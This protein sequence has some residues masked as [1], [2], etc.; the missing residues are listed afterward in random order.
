MN[1]DRGRRAIGWIVPVVVVGVWQVVVGS[2]LL[3]LESVPAPDGVA[4]ALL[5][6]IKSGDLVEDLLYTG[7]ITVLATLLAVTVGGALGLAI[8]LLPPLRLAVMASVDVLRTVP[9]VALMPIALLALGPLPGTEVLLAVWAAQW[10]VLI[11]VAGAVRAVPDRLYDVGRMARLSRAAMLRTIV[12]PAVVPA[13]L[14]GARLATIIALHVAIT[15][16]MVM[17]PNGLGGAMVRSMQSLDVER[18]FAYAVVCGI[19][20]ALVSAGLRRLVAAGLPGSTA[21]PRRGAW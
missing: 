5:D 17:A 10:P 7:G 3:H 11:N 14:V 4:R 8:G 2:G 19:V 18:V 9:A 13:G 1:T 21:N 6:V 12:V 16:E 15:A 20:G